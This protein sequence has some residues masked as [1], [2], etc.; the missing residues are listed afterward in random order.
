MVLFRNMY[1]TNGYVEWRSFLFT[2]H[3]DV[4]YLVFLFINLQLTSS[5]SYTSLSCL[6]QYVFMHIKSDY[7]QVELDTIWSN[8]TSVLWKVCSPFYNYEK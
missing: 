7:V 5:I 6:T 4:F 2:K 8:F 3:C 1:R